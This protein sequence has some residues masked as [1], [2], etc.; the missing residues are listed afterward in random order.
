MLNYEG[1][2]IA[3]RRLSEEVDIELT[4]LL[5]RTEPV[6]P[7]TAAHADLARKIELWRGRAANMEKAVRSK[8]GLLTVSHASILKKHGNYEAKQSFNSKMGNMNRLRK[9]LLKLLGK[10][11]DLINAAT[12]PV[13]D[14]VAIMNGFKSALKAITEGGDE[15]VLNPQQ[16]QK[17]TAEISKASGPLEPIEGYNPNQPIGLLTLALVMFVTAKKLLGRN[18]KA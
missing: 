6:K 5:G 14:E 16:S 4:K 2:V 13:S 17:L 7:G 10:I 15:I 11:A 8:E 12:N 3:I 18:G 9:D 1:Q